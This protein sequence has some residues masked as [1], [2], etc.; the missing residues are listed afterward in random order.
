MCFSRSNEREGRN[1]AGVIWRNNH[2]WVNYKFHSHLRN[3]R[4]KPFMEVIARGA[5]TYSVHKHIVVAAM[6]QVWVL[7]NSE[8]FDQTPVSHVGCILIHPRSAHT[9]SPKT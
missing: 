1:R 9:S 6:W 8:H 7:S 5:L 3:T 4:G 2:N